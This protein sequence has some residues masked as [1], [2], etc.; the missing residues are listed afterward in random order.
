MNHHLSSSRL[1]IVDL[2]GGGELAS[3]LVLLLQ[4]GHECQVGGADVNG[5]ADD[6]LDPGFALNGVGVVALVVV[7]RCSCHWLRYD[8]LELFRHELE[9]VDQASH[10]ICFRPLFER[11]STVFS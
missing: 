1:Q 5:L 9:L 11:I 8:R 7:V 4:L 10:V 2:T 3:D 6:H